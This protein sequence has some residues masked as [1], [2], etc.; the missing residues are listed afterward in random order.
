MRAGQPSIRMVIVSSLLA[1]QLGCEKGPTLVP[2]SGHVTM[3]GKPLA[4]VEVSF[5]PVVHGPEVAYASGVTDG[6]GAFDLSTFAK[7]VAT[8]GAVLGENRVTIS[9]PSHTATKKVPN[10]DRNKNLDP[11]PP[12][13]NRDSTL[14]FTVPANGTDKADFPLSSR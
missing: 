4:G 2:V 7:G 14:T 12:K 1:A 11:I 5:Y 8:G 9:T 3:D 10:A 13:Y 6:Q